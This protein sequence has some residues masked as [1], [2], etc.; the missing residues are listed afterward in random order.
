LT[1]IKEEATTSRNGEPVNPESPDQSNSG[2]PTNISESQT[3]EALNAICQTIRNL[4]TDASVKSIRGKGIV[5]YY[6]AVRHAF[7]SDTPLRP[8]LEIYGVRSS[9]QIDKNLKCIWG[10]TES[11][12]RGTDPRVRVI[13]MNPDNFQ[14]CWEE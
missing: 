1:E 7:D 10:I 8:F 13:N 14:V 3:R 9:T 2:A 4:S 5:Y 11:I 12:I 6:A